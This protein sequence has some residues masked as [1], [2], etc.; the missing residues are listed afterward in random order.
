MAGW[1]IPIIPG[2]YHPNGRPLMTP[3]L[4]QA[5]SPSHGEKLSPQCGAEAENDG[6]LSALTT[7]TAFEE[8]LKKKNLAHVFFCLGT[9]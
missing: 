5:V 3:P 2:K 6:S 4:I 7:A 1:K 9:G 8:V